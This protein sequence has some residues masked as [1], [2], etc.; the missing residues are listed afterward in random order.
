MDKKQIDVPEIQ[1]FLKLSRT[2]IRQLKI[3]MKSNM[4]EEH[5]KIVET[6]TQKVYKENKKY[7]E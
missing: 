1:E 3:M 4:S 6:A 7:I 5:R 2:Y